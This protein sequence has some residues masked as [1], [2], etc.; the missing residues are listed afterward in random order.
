[1]A[2]NAF[3]DVVSISDSNYIRIELFK[4]ESIS[5]EKQRALMTMKYARLFGRD[6]VIPLVNEQNKD[7][8]YYSPITIGGQNFTVDLDTGSSDLWVPGIQCSSTQCGTHNRFDPAKSSTFVP[9]Q[10]NFSISYG[11][12]TAINGTIGQDTVIFGGISITNLT[13]GI[14]LI[15]G[16]NSLYEEDGILGLA[17]RNGQLSNPGIIQRIKDQ[18]LLNQTIIGFHLGRYK[19]NNT[20]Q[21]FV[22]L[23]GTDAN[24]Y[25]G[26]IVYNNLANQT[27]LPGSW[28][29][30]LSNIQVDGVSIGINSPALIDTGT[31][32]IIGDTTQVTKIYAM[33]PGSSSNNGVWSIPCNTTKIISLVFNNISYNISPTELIKSS[34]QSGSLCES[35]IQEGGYGVWVIGAAFLSNVYTVFDYDNLRIGFAESKV[36]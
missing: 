10:S 27:Q 32:N 11:T 28:I 18:K 23:G 12:G 6:T 35:E 24:A 36:L 3:S 7:F 31:P 22:N 17:R 25:I 14:A 8:S 20:D 4:R 15:D 16:F 33:I 29:I 13:F 2:I 5:P 30:S 19:L 34:N 1:M 9:L 26:N 21:S